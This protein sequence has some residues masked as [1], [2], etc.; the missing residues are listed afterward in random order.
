MLSEHE[1]VADEHNVGN[2]ATTTSELCM[3]MQQGDN[4]GNGGGDGDTNIVLTVNLG[5]VPALPEDIFKN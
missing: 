1:R 5:V 3:N 4:N 2:P